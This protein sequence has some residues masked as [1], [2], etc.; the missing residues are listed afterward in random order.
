RRRGWLFAGLA[1][2]YLA[3]FTGQWR[4][5]EDSALYLTLAR[6]LAEGEGYRFGGEWHRFGFPGLPWLMTPLYRLFGQAAPDAATWLML[7]L[8]GL[9]LAGAYRLFRLHAGTGVATAMVVSVGVC[10]NF[11]RYAFQVRND[12]PY[13]LGIV[14]VLAGYE[15]LRRGREGGGRPAVDWA[16]VA[17]GMALLTCMRPVMLVFHAAVLA[18]CAWG[19]TRGPRRAMHAGLAAISVAA[20]A[21]FFAADPRHE[22]A[23]PPSS[24]APVTATA[25]NLQPT[26]TAAFAAPAENGAVPR[27]ESKLFAKIERLPETL[28]QGMGYW[29]KLTWGGLLSEA[30]LGIELGHGVFNAAFAAVLLMAGLWLASQRPLWGLFVAA[31]VGQMLLYPPIE[32]YV[33]PMIPLLLYA[34][35]VLL[36]GASRRLSQER[37]KWL[38]TGVVILAVGP[39]L[40]LDVALIA[41]QR[42]PDTYA[43]QGGGRFARVPGMADAVETHVPPD[44]VLISDEV[45]ILALLT[46]RNGCTAGQAMRDWRTGEDEDAR[47]HPPRGQVWAV[48]R[49]PPTAAQRSLLEQPAVRIVREAARVGP[50][51]EAAAE[52]AGAATDLP[53]EERGWRLVRLAFE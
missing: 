33:L 52:D 45:R 15:G 39:N 53:E 9:T 5:G 47:W 44:A 42:A 2:L 3:G 51:T 50:A 34:G 17:G 31:N 16:M 22:P 24:Q 26:G 1:G 28:S 11:Y 13:L 43:R 36:R 29:A 27:Y 8:A 40:G 30:V 48:L 7:L 14:A 49:I 37:A 10:E 18:A 12:M 25:E 6:S 4:I 32:R 38:V 20:M 19:V 21:L 46:R 23:P 35:W 41:E